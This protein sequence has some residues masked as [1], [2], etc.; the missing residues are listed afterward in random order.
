MSKS[1]IFIQRLGNPMGIWCRPK[2]WRAA[3][4]DRRWY[5]H[6]VL[7]DPDPRFRLSP[8]LFTC[9]NFRKV[10]TTPAFKAY[11]SAVTGLPLGKLL[12]RTFHRMR[13]EDIL[14]PHSDEVKGRRLTFIVYLSPTWRADY[15]GALH[16]IGKNDACS[17]IEATFNSLVVFG[18]TTQKSHYVADIRS[19]RRGPVA[20]DDQWLVLWS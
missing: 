12:G 15:G 6:G 10:L 16:V 11:V 7:S 4:E 1:I 19:T 20:V 3:D 5:T 2:S 14:G 13:V 9:L 17:K 8:N 18:L